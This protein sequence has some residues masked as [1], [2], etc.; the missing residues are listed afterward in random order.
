M[1]DGQLRIAGDEL[2]LDLA[3]SSD[4]MD[5]RWAHYER[6]Y[7]LFLVR[8]PISPRDDVAADHLYTYQQFYGLLNWQSEL[9]PDPEVWFDVDRLSSHRRYH[10]GIDCSDVSRV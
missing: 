5:P 9:D 7:E 6:I 3:D 10:L 1:I 2:W 4:C 8:Y